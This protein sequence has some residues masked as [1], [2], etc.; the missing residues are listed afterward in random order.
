MMMMLKRN[1][2]QRV[3]ICQ[4]VLKM[5]DSKQARKKSKKVKTKEK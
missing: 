4:G 1:N 5:M 3:I 2:K